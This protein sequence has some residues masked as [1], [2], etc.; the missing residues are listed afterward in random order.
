MLF[1]IDKYEAVGMWNETE[2]WIF[3]GG[4]NRIIIKI[5]IKWEYFLI[6][7]VWICVYY[8]EWFI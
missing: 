1:D 2:K 7:I 5:N 8:I 4:V 6:I 3:G